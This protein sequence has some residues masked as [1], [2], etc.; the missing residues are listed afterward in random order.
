MLVTAQNFLSIFR[1]LRDLLGS[2]VDQI[3]IPP[4]IVFFFFFFF[5]SVAITNIYAGRRCWMIGSN[6]PC[7]SCHYEKVVGGDI[8]MTLA[9]SGTRSV[10]R[11]KCPYDNSPLTLRNSSGLYG[12]TRDTSETKCM[13]FSLTPTDSPALRTPTGCPRVRL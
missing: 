13:E 7:K 12:P 11:A 10:F 2:S 9:L 3:Q 6:V 4:L 5:P 8:Q 1:V